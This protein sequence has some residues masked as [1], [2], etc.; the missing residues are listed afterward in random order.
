MREYRPYFRR[1]YNVVSYKLHGTETVRR[2][3]QRRQY[4]CPDKLRLSPILSSEMFSVEDIYFNPADRDRLYSLVTQ[5]LS[6]TFDLLGSGPV[7]VSTGAGTI[8]WHRDFKCGYEWPDACLGEKEAINLPEGADIKTV[9]ELQRM[10]WLPAYGLVAGLFPEQRAEIIAE[11]RAEIEDFIK[12]NPVGSGCNWV[13]SMDPAIRIV[14]CLI[15]YS[16]LKPLDSEDVLDSVFEKSFAQAV[17]L[18]GKFIWDN[19]ECDVNPRRRENANHFYADILGL[20]YAGAALA[21]DREADRWYACGKKLFIEETLA[22]FNPDGSNIECSTSYHRLM[23]EMLLFGVAVIIRRDGD[24]PEKVKNCLAGAIDFWHAVQKGDG[25]YVQIGDNDSGHI[26]HNEMC[27]LEGIDGEALLKGIFQAIAGKPLKSVLDGHRAAADAYRVSIRE[28]V[29]EDYEHFSVQKEMRFTYQPLDNPNWGYYPDFGL[30]FYREG[31][32]EFFCYSGGNSGRKRTG[33]SHNDFLHCEISIGGKPVT[34]DPGT[35]LY[36]KNPY[37]G[38]FR[39]RTG[40]FVPDYGI[41]PREMAGS[42][43]YGVGDACQVLECG[44][45]CLLL[46][47]SFQDKVHYR[48]IIIENGALIIYDYGNAEFDNRVD[49]AFPYYSPGYGKLE[50]VKEE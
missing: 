45:G 46:R 33:H 2:A 26:I 32:L 39:G 40:H 48:K 41:E 35:Y 37:T 28:A 4:R 5:Y 21:G 14:N 6:H 31:N 16:M 12:N 15:S 8:N 49:F 34:R 42:W 10:E 20:L 1:F 25:T 11:Y 17:Y 36:I 18:C 30:Y 27:G 7:D 13:L 3:R 9:W 43:A 44:Q 38:Y 23:T 22:Q 47:H 50:T 24:V 19:P 29:P